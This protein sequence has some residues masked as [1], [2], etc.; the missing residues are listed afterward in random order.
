MG[1][2]GFRLLSNWSTTPGTGPDGVIDGAALRQ[3]M[4]DARRLLEEADRLR[5]GEEHIGKVLASSPPDPDGTWPGVE[6]RN[7]L[8]ELQNPQIEAGVAM[9]ILNGRGFTSRSPDEGGR[10]EWDLAEEYRREG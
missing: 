3:W 10:Q 4:V 1:S 8:E 9:A 2:N 7:L 6:V 5:I